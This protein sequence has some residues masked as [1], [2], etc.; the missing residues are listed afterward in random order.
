MPIRAGATADALGVESPL[1][2]VLSRSR[3]R[4]RRGPCGRGERPRRSPAHPSRT[5]PHIP[6]M[7]P[8]A[9]AG[10]PS[11][12]A[13][14][15]GAEAGS[16]RVACPASVDTEVRRRIGLRQHVAAACP[17]VD[18]LCRGREANRG[19]EQQSDQATHSRRAHPPCSIRTETRAPSEA[20]VC[21]VY[22]TAWRR[23]ARQILASRRT[24]DRRARSGSASTR[25]P[26][27]VAFLGHRLS[28]PRPGRHRRRRQAETRQ[29]AGRLSSGSEYASRGSDSL[30]S[31]SL[32]PGG[33]IAATGSLRNAWSHGSTS[34]SF[35]QPAAARVS[36]RT[37]ADSRSGSSSRLSVGRDG[38][39]ADGGTA[40]DGTPVAE[41]PLGVLAEGAVGAGREDGEAVLPPRGS[42][43]AAERLTA[44]TGASR[45]VVVVPSPSCPWAFAP[46]PRTDPSSW[47]ARLKSWPAATAPAGPAARC[48]AAGTVDL[49]TVAELAVVVLPPRPDAAVEVSASE[50]WNPAAIAVTP[51][52]P[53]VCTGAA[54][55]P[56]RPVAELAVSLRAPSKD[57]A[58]V[59]RASVWLPPPDDRNDP[60][61]P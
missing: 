18:A 16:D 27:D 38:D 26:L 40:I 28:L 13:G 51:A 34:S 39:D 9:R 1:L 57:G 4:G 5:S 20:R 35:P 8:R 45:A 21:T 46:Q 15:C 12:P 41:L 29:D 23:R 52:R 11:V 3:T 24:A 25:D 61:R 53:F 32:P 2:G 42:A 17:S 47:S 7:A 44:G 48:G 14:C 30:V 31:T 43:V 6:E 19:S 55:S 50:C 60:R 33:T 36:S 22:R 37:S 56:R 49:R 54:A 59:R 58:V 10:S